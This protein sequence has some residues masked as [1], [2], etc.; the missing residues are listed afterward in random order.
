[1][2]EVKEFIMRV[3]EFSQR[4]GLPVSTLH[5]YERRGLISPVRNAS[6]HREYDERDVAWIAFINR[7]RETGMPL[8]QIAVYSELRERG[9]ETLEA[10][11][12]ILE[13]HR[14][15]VN[16]EIERWRENKRHLDEK[17]TF[18]ERAIKYYKNLGL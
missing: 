10:R 12:R 6:G 4:V 5:F 11:L 9:D 13:E 2:V 17:I 7:L 15:T 3:G 14:E 18:Y 8:A 1:M 16:A